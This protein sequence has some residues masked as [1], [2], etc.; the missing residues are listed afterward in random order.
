MTTGSGPPAML[1]VLCAGAA[2]GLVA[3][4]ES[5]FTAASGAA[6]DGTFGAVGA[7]R[8]KLVAGAPCDVIVVTAALIGTL[9]MDGLVAHGSAAPLGAVQT[10]IAVRAGEPVPDIGDARSLRAS[11]AG[12]TRLLI[13]DP[14]RATAGIHFVD[15]L[16]RLGIHDE[17]ADR[18]AAFPNG[19]AAMR[20]LA[21]SRGRGEV[22]CTQVTEINYTPGAVLAG[23]L[24]KGFDLSTVYAAAV[25][26]RA[27]NRDLAQ[28]LVQLLCGEGSRDA[29]VRGGFEI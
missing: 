17:V 27:G 10:G 5:A 24:P 19:A 21:Q 3:A 4:M 13:P 9:E 28:R 29:R 8:E 11:L 20:A 12:A 16:R 15:V 6:I 18:L 25:C 2:K 23:S 1:A 22:G 14:Q 26:T 7:L